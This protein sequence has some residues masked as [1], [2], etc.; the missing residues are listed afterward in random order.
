MKSVIIGIHG[1]GNKPPEEILRSWWLKSIQEGLV[2]AGL[3]QMDVPFDIAYWADINHPAPLDPQI[4]NKSDALFLD[5]PYATGGLEKRE[6]GSSL[7]AD[8]LK[9]IEGQVDRIFLNSDMSIN[10]RKVTDK[11]IHHFFSDLESYYGEHCKLALDQDCSA[12]EAIQNSLLRKI[13]QYRGYRILLIAHSMGSIVAYDV[14]SEMPGATPVHTFVTI[15]SPLGFP[16]IVGKISAARKARGLEKLRPSALEGV[17]GSWLN[18]SDKRDKI[19]LDHTLS[20]DYRENT[21]GQQVRDMY[22][23]NDYEVNGNP[24]PHKS[25]GYLRTPEMAGVINGFLE[26]GRGRF[27]KGYRHLIERLSR[28]IKT[29]SRVVNPGREKPQR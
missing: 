13:E 20:D 6:E 21:R 23:Y 27:Y 9:Y 10:F 26:G 5:E 4:R 29:F 28:G 18:M 11:V 22:V 15:G 7:L 24:N 3:G 16:V 8:F 1:L 19:A 12:R 14:L 25:Y 2:R 17:S